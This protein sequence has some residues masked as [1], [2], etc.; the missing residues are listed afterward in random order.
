MKSLF[1]LVSAT[2][3]EPPL[4]CPPLGKQ[5][6]LLK[7]CKELA[8]PSLPLFSCHYMSHMFASGSLLLPAV[9]LVFLFMHMQCVVGHLFQEFQI[10]NLY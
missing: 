1:F 2:R 5:H 3:P 6:L 4:S 7:I 9:L 8:G 10:P